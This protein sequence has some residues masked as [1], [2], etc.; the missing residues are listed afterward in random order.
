MND[1]DEL[2]D[3]SNANRDP[4]TGE[5]GSHPLG[6]GIGSAGGA[7]AGAALG[8]AVGGPA[9]AL[10]GGTVGAVAGAVTG[11]VAGEGAKPTG[12]AGSAPIE[13]PLPGKSS[14]LGL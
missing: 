14:I 4:L 7:A 1:L 9:G 2:V 11:H 10:V 6:T 12:A 13:D 8:A 5:P 3:S